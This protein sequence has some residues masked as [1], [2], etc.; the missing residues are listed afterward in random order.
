MAYWQKKKKNVCGGY[1]KSL[2][3]PAICFQS[4]LNSIQRSQGGEALRKTETLASLSSSRCRRAPPHPPPLVPT[5]QAVGALSTEV[6]PWL[7]VWH[8]SSLVPSLPSLFP[9]HIPAPWPSLFL[10]NQLCLRHF[11]HKP[12]NDTVT[13]SFGASEG[14][15]RPENAA[16]GR[17][18]KS[19]Y[20][21]FLQTRCQICEVGITLTIPGGS[22]CHTI[23][24]SRNLVHTLFFHASELRE[25]I[26]FYIYV[27]V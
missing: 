8:V 24:Q 9:A 4:F 26:E 15:E 21:Q 19:L 22:W 5:L 25:K 14:T 16:G 27:C 12:K 13:L 17:W 10:E 18:T 23:S 2:C 3:L 11:S 6:W 7:F 20:N 1:P